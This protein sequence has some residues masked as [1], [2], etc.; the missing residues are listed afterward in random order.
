MRN[1]HNINKIF[2]RTGVYL[3]SIDAD[4]RPYQNKQHFQGFI[5]IHKEWK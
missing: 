5:Q 2:E 3:L 1:R 4:L